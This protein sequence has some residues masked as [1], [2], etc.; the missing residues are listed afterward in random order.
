ML[1]IGSGR[2][3][4]VPMI[5]AQR[6][7]D[8]GDDT[9]TEQLRAAVEDARSAAKRGETVPHEQVREWLLELAQGKTRPPPL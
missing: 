4:L 3:H 9:E 6:I 8:D 7:A 2:C 1:D 5:Q